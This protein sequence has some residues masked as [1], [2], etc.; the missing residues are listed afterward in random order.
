MGDKNITET[1]TDWNSKYDVALEQAVF[2][3]IA[4]WYKQF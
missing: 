1:K 3:W 2:R 4:G